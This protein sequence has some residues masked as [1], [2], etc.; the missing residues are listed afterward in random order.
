MLEKPNLPDEIIITRLREKYE[1]FVGGLEFLP[2]GNDATAWVYRV[3]VDDGADYFLKVKRGAVYPPALLVPRYLKDNGIEAV[4]APLPTQNGH[5]WVNTGEFNLILYP[6]IEGENGMDAGLSKSQWIELGRILKQLHIA[7]LPASVEQ[8]TSRETFVPAWQAM[9]ERLDKTI[10][11]T[12]S[13][14]APY[15]NELADFWRARGDEIRHIVERAAVL[16][17]TLRQKMLAFVLCHADIHGANVLV[18][19]DGGLHIV[20]WDQPIFAPKERD[21]MFVVGSDHTAFVLEGY[22]QTRIDPLALAYYHY[23]W[24]VQEIGDYGERVFVTQNAGEETLSDSL[25]GFQQLFAP[26]DVVDAAYEADQSIF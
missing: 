9:V 11:E 22:G 24:V 15:K 1:I 23:E 5:L 12:I 2:I 4:V 3:R 26:G 21:L 13:F 20:D 16:G 18:T 14:D 25:R 10:H 6:F 7:Q 17:R 8:V 19:A